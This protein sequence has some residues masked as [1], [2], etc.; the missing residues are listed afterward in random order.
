MFHVRPNLAVL[1]AFLALLAVASRAPGQDQE[2]KSDVRKALTYFANAAD[3]QNGGAFE[4][5]ADQWEKFVHE[6]PNDS[7]ASTA[8]HHLGICNLQRKEPNLNRAIEA[9]REAL[10]DEKND[11]REESF[12]NLGWALFTHASKSQVNSEKQR[13]DLSEARRYFSKVIEDY[14]DGAYLDQAVFY[15]GEAEHLLGNHRQAIGYF[16]QFLANKKLNHSTLR[17]EALYGL[18]VAL[19]Q[20]RQTPEALQRFQEFINEYG[21][22]RLANEV[23]L[24]YAELLVADGKLSEAEKV[25]TGSSTQSDAPLADLTLMRQGAIASQLGNSDHAAAFYRKLIAE[26]PT[27]TQASN[28]RFLLGHID[29]QAGRSDQA[30]AYFREVVQSD[31]PA[32]AD[33]AHSLAK[34][35]VQQNRNAEAIEVLQAAVERFKEG[36]ALL[37]LQMDL[38][39]VFSKIPDRNDDA[40]KIY[41]QI[42]NG[43]PDS[44]QAPQAVYNLAFNELE[45]GRYRE[46]QQW[47]ER[48]LTRYPSDPLRSD[49][50][51]VAAESLLKQGQHTGAAEALGKLIETD[52]TNANSDLWK[53]RQ[54]M[55][56]YLAGDYE[57][58]AQNTEKLIGQLSESVQKAE[59]QFI[60][61][62]SHLYQEHLDSA[63]RFLEASYAT[64]IQWSSADEVLLL[65]GEAYQRQN[66]SSDARRALM[67]LLD[68]HPSSRLEV[69]AQYKLAQLAAAEGEYPDAVKRYRALTDNPNASSFHNFALYGIVWCLMQQDQYAQAFEELQPLLKKDLRDSIGSEALLAEGVCLRNLDKPEAAEDAFRRFLDRKPSGISLANGLYELSLTLSSLKKP[70]QAS[71]AQE[72]IIN[73]VPNY[74]AMDQV[75]FELGWN[76]IDQGKNAEAT[77]AF[78]RLIHNHP[79]SSLAAEARLMIAQHQYDNGNYQAAIENY[80]AVA[81]LTNDDA[82]HEKAL[83]KL[84]WS[85]FQLLQYEAAAKVF[86]QQVARFASGPLAVDGLFMQ[87]ECDFKLERF[88][89]AFEQYERAR[90]ALEQSTD[91]DSISAQV[92]TLIYLHA[93]QCLR[94]LER[95]D[96]CEQWLRIVIEK[97]SSSPYL[98]TAL[99]ELGNC[100]QNQAKIDEAIVHYTEAADNYRNEAAARSR[101]MLGEIYFARK[102][103]AKAIPEFQRVMYGFGRD[104][105]PED[106]QKWQAKSAFEAAR[107][108]EALIQ[109]LSGSARKKVVETTIEFYE[110]V[111]DKRDSSA[112]LASQ[113]QAR[114][115][116]LQKLR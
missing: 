77:E 59:A 10:K 74:P 109:S 49:V 16:K 111:L 80:S 107:C 20:E 106:I 116:E 5:A 46:A 61:G 89:T 93:G 40:R 81:K 103:F 55:A 34:V 18:A 28:A 68:E 11:L 60:A 56:L 7:Q 15:S 58:A 9:F 83:H 115:G 64:D 35:L 52:R 1:L 101:F 82:L 21:T 62:A 48:F 70:S 90:E 88:D 3:Y 13:K 84:G 51:Y 104:K 30:I 44:S 105:A 86:E 22:H 100:K 99:Y 31:S 41:E 73:E 96:E 113:A 32:S 14:A 24:R 79:S 75:L 25:L 38:A 91:Q 114:L 97:H 57:L 87:A 78:S 54:G 63:I 53:L 2:Q 4:L 110:Y 102:D 12:I 17:P 8:W 27:S 37:E 43:S 26:F 72:R 85:Q 108:S 47:A 94:E 33:A 39:D 76:L 65:L 6:F 29:L 69:Q 23:R 95:W 98:P 67:R 66:K 112:E 45:T 71:A 36:P 42:A 50:A 19:E 92:R